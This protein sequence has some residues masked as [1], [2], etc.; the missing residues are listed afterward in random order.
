L[1]GP[2]LSHYRI[3]GKVGSG[4]M[5]VVY[6]AEDLRLGRAVA[7]KLLPEEL[8]K[9]P[10][11]IERFRREARAAS[12]LNHPGI[13]TVHDV[14]FDEGRPFIVM[15]LLEGRSLKER[16]G[17]KPLGVPEILD[18]GVQI[19]DALEA[20]HGKGI[21]HRDIK[22]AN[23]F[24]T[25]RG[26]AKLLDFGL[27]KQ[28]LR[29][30]GD[31][32]ESITVTQADDL[33]GSGAVVGTVTYMSPEQ[34]RG[35]EADWRTDLFSF[36]VVLYQMATGAVPFNGATTSAVSL[37][38]LRDDPTPP[39]Q[40]NPE[41]PP[42]L[43]A[44]ILRALEKD[45]DVRYQTASDM[46][47]ELKRLKRD[48][49]STGATPAMSRRAPRRML[50]AGLA[51]GCLAGGGAAW[52]W[53][54]GARPARTTVLPPS[55]FMLKRFAVQAFEGRTHAAAPDPLGRTIAA[56]V[57]H[58]L[59]TIG[60]LEVVAPSAA[61]AVITGSYDVRGGTLRLDAQLTASR[62]QRLLAVVGPV[63]G[64]QDEAIGRLTEAIEGRAATFADPILA[65]YARALHLPNYAAYKEGVKGAELFLSSN[66]RDAIP[67]LQR[68]IDLDGSFFWAMQAEAYAHMLLGR[69]PESE[70]L[71]Q[72]LAS[73][74]E[75]LTPY[76]QADLETFEAILRGDLAGLY[77]GQRRK[78]ELVPVAFR[79]YYVAR[80]AFALNRPREALALLETLDP[81][82]PGI[83]DM[84]SY[85]E[86]LTA[87][88][89][90]LGDHALELEDAGRGRRQLP[91]RLGA[92]CSEG[93]ALAALGR[94][95]DVAALLRESVALPPDPEWTPGRVMEAIAAELEAHD[96]PDAGRAALDRALAWYS[97]RPP[98]E[99]SS[100]ANRYGMARTQYARGR[101]DE[102]RALFTA[103]HDEDP[104]RLDYSAY[105][106]LVAARQGRT[107]EAL[108]VADRLRTLEKP[109]L[110]GSQTLWRA[111]I[112]A[113]LGDDDAVDLLRQAMSQG[114][115]FT[116][117]LHADADFAR[118]RQDRGFRELL[119]PKG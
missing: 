16:I 91:D 117:G 102:A 97:D 105:L 2:T 104:D 80:A 40:R 106:G 84:P 83:R 46:K 112:A 73:S 12:S 96:H 14:D 85:W 17:G 10:R 119:E 114:Q 39:S 93:R 41:L 21:V 108:E 19:A 26:Q 30:T 25:T 109:H 24:V 115:G 66:Y 111:H 118:L 110:F 15:E 57:E 107:D 82:T 31:A 23:I 86:I 56:R 92:L 22:P 74:R 63:T 33:T 64:S 77:R 11:A 58:G 52:L 6:R 32:S 34:A 75:R 100:Q 94:T 4:G 76:E 103:L 88:R 113:V 54:S 47:A 45:R 8:T 42:A 49:E 1:I 37:A 35:D 87:A 5:G 98:S 20:A 18:L 89:H 78:M 36:G 28:G 70:A 60:S 67:H 101:W 81:T 99:A 44:V 43:E 71:G 62:D 69:F 50:L 72:R 68:A 9:E 7:L 13:C 3:V 38:I 90:T 61:D 55:A 65:P 29:G 51:L 59:G 27:A 116:V 48:G 53:W 79:L 95:D